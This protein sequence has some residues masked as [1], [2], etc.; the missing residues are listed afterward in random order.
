MGQKVAKENVNAGVVDNTG[1]PLADP[2]KLHRAPEGVRLSP[3]QRFKRLGEIDEVAEAG[4][5]RKLLYL[6]L[7]VF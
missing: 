1:Y 7:G 4:S 2:E 6:R 5:C 3:S